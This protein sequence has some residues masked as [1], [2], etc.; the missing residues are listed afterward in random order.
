MRY[1]EGNNNNN[2]NNNN[3]HVPDHFRRHHVFSCGRPSVIWDVEKPTSTGRVSKVL[4]MLAKPKALPRE[5][6]LHRDVLTEIPLSALKVA[7]TE[8][9]DQL[10]APKK[11]PEGPFRQPMWP[12][13]VIIG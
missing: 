12:V 5:F 1:V 6:A 7:P 11:R 13:G 9:L 8:H 3:I 10:S 4:E 2:N